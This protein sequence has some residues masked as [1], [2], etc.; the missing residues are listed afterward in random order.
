MPFIA[1]ALS[2]IV[3]VSSRVRSTAAAQRA[4][5]LVSLPVTLASYEV[6]SG[7]LYDPT[8]A[9]LAVRAFA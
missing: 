9:A 1:V 3:W 2:I 4:A 6:S 5:S 7:L 8:G